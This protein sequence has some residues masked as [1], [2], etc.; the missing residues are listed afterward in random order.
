MHSVLH[1]VRYVYADA[2]YI[3]YETDACRSGLIACLLMLPIVLPMK[4]EFL[5]TKVRN[6]AS[7]EACLIHNIIP[8]GRVFFGYIVVLNCRK[9]A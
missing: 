7:Q 5:R 9:P 3:L 1:V 2:A 6:V 4:F 8:W